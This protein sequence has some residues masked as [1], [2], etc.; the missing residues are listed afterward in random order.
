MSAKVT[1]IDFTVTA[2]RLEDQLLGKLILKEKHELEEQRQAPWKRSPR[3]RRRSSSWRMTC[4]TA[5]PTPPEP[6]DDVE[7]IDVLNNTKQTAQ[8]VVAG[9]GGGVNVKITEACEEYARWRTA[10][11]IYFLIAEFAT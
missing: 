9:D 6:L 7:L 5:W 1:V 10:P 8:D 11:P 3:T 4:Y 2:V